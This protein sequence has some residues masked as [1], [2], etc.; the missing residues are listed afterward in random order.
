MA[1]LNEWLAGVNSSL[2][3]TSTASFSGVQKTINGTTVKVSSGYYGIIPTTLLKFSIMNRI[4]P[5]STV[6]V[7]Y[8]VSIL[9]CQVQTAI[10]NGFDVVVTDTGTFTSTTST[11]AV[12]FSYS[13]T[14]VLSGHEESFSALVG[15]SHTATITVTVV[16]LTPSKEYTLGY[17]QA[18]TA[19]SV[20]ATSDSSGM[21]IFT[22]PGADGGQI[23]LTSLA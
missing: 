19:K 9:D 15:A 14:Q 20:K 12:L 6:P 23:K 13:F 16:N 18:G 8:R 11:K 7:D 5:A 2:G 4:A 17:D 3:G 1:L 10:P 21:A 22:V